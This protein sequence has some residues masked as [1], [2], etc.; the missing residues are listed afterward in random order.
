MKKGIAFKIYEAYL[1]VDE[2][3]QNIQLAE[4]A[5]KTAEEGTRLLKLRYENGLSPLSDLLNIQASLEQARAGVVERKNGHQSA[6]AQLSFESGTILQ[7]LNIESQ[8]R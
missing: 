5:L 2:A 3:R 8:V 4:E 6:L 1:N 7:D